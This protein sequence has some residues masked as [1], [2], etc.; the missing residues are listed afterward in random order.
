MRRS[1]TNKRDTHINKASFTKLYMVKKIITSLFT[2]KKKRLNMS[3]TGKNHF[4]IIA[5]ICA[6]AAS[7]FGKLSGSADQTVTQLQVNV[8]YTYINIKTQSE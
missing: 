4:A 8:L 5:G 3:S 7:F 1:V 6:S 2:D